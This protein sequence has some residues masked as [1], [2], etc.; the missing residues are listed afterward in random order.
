MTRVDWCSRSVICFATRA[1]T[2]WPPP[3]LLNLFATLFPPLP[4]HRLLF[5]SLFTFASPLTPRS[6]ST[7]RQ[8]CVQKL[9]KSPP[10][11]QNYPL[12]KTI[13]SALEISSFVVTLLI[14][15]GLPPS[16]RLTKPDVPVNMHVCMTLETEKRPYR[17]GAL[18]QMRIPAVG[19]VLIACFF[20]I[21][22]YYNISVWAKIIAGME[23]RNP[24]SMSPSEH[25]MIYMAAAS[26]RRSPPS[27]PT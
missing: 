20:S 10:L 12:Q 11:P 8:S 9:S 3:P 22:N 26:F 23:V 4:L 5:L 19:S 27:L 15:T 1:T 25:S 24:Q 16:T 18:L 17:F 13:L 14:L 21:P 2:R 6:H 7:Y